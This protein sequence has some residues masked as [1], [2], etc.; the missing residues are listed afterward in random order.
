[1]NLQTVFQHFL[2]LL[3]GVPLTLQLVLL[4]LAFGFALGCVTAFLR[5]GRVPVLS[6]LAGFY[7][8]VIRGTPLLV[9]I[10]LIYFGLG[11]T[12]AR[13]SAAPCNRSSTARSRPPWPTA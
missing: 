13:R 6:Q 1:V 8:Y 11:P 5:M 12:P 7:V 3:A 9:Q 4:A 2:T 10:F